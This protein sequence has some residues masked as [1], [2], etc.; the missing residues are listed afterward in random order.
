MKETVSMCIDLMRQVEKVNSILG[1]KSR[2]SLVFYEYPL[3]FFLSVNQSI[4]YYL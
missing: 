3:S 1:E 2:W 4:F